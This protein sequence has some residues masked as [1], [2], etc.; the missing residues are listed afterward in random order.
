VTTVE[1]FDPGQLEAV[2]LPRRK[3]QHTGETAVA[4]CLEGLTPE[5]HPRGMRRPHA[6][7]R[8][9]PARGDR[10]EPVQGAYPSGTSQR[11]A[12]GGSVSSAE[13]GWPCHGEGSASTPP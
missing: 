8:L 5:S 10:P 7:L 11:A 3:P 6:E 9:A 12:S 2:F 4:L 1:R 13:N